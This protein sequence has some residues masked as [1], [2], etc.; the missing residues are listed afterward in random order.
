MKKIIQ[1]IKENSNKYPNAIHIKGKST[2]KNVN[3][4]G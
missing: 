1:K 2:T 4:A 3:I